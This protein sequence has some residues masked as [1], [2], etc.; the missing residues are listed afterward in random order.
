MFGE[1]PLAEY[2][3]WDFKRGRLFE[4]DI[5][6]H[7]GSS[8][9]H[10]S[11][12]PSGS[13]LLLA[14]F[15]CSSFRLMEESVGMALHSVLGGS[16]GGFHSV[17]VKPCHFRFSVASKAVGFLVRSLKRITTKKID[18]YF[19]LWRDGGANWQ[20]E[21][22]DWEK[23][24]EDQWTVVTNKKCGKAK[25]IRF[26]SP[27]KLPSSMVKSSPSLLPQAIKFGAFSCDLKGQS[28]VNSSPAEAVHVFRVF[29]KL[30]NYLFQNSNS[31]LSI[32]SS[33]AEPS[34]VAASLAPI[35]S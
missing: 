22:K 34:S 13:F 9:H 12:S 14:V 11:S 29:G 8:V 17:C 23:E 32:C 25:Q 19:H 7:L 2:E 24:E 6:L 18:V 3:H 21:F 31:Q 16:P 35:L 4:E 26:S 27:I 20:I 10:P 5:L 33:G 30:K 15:R 1:R 28:S